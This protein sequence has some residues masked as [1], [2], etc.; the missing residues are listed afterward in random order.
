MQVSN[1]N[2]MLQRRAGMK[3][4]DGLFLAMR[5]QFIWLGP[6]LTHLA[7]PFREEIAV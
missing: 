3:V 6:G 1:N 2:S 5:Q 7:K 4:R